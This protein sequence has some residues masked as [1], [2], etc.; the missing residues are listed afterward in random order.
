MT[1]SR[2][3]FHWRRILAQLYPSC[4]ADTVLEMGTATAGVREYIV[5][6]VTVVEGGLSPHLLPLDTGKLLQTSIHL[7][8]LLGK[9]PLLLCILSLLLF[10]RV[11]FGVE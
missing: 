1:P 7:A 5:A 6:Q 8:A 2:G 4:V 3:R 10:V 11:L 9:S